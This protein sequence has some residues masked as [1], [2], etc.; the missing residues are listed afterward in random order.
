MDERQ[1]FARLVS[2]L[3]Q[4]GYRQIAYIG[5]PANLMIQRERFAGYCLGVEQ[6]GISLNPDWIKEG[7]LTET[8]GY[9][10]AVQL[11]SGNS[12]PTAIM[13]CN[14]L[15]ALGALQAAQE[16]G[17]RVGSELAITGFDGIKDTEYTTPPIT[18]LYQPTYEIARNLT[19]ILGKIINGASPEGM[20]LTIE[21]ELIL[22]ASSEPRSG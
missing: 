7:N 5:A 11:L 17:V 1:G 18:T 3:V 4:N 9:N 6:T 10:A 22:R 12:A 8:S 15:M 2:H 19:T 21:P 16:M 13:A 14:D 20:S